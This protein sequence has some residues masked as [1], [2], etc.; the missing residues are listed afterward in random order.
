MKDVASYRGREGDRIVLLGSG[1]PDYCDSG[2]D[3]GFWWDSG[4]RSLDCRGL[5]RSILNPAGGLAD[6]RVARAAL[7]MDSKMIG[8]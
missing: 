4:K 1:L 6:I 3:P 5:V 8:K 2:G 7:D